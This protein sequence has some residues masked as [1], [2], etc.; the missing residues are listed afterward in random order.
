MLRGT[1]RAEMHPS[2]V[3]PDEKRLPVGVGTVDESESVL[4]DLLVDGFHAL[5]CQR[6]GVLDLLAAVAVGPAM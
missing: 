2:R 5:Y 3:V 4:G 6:S 1:M